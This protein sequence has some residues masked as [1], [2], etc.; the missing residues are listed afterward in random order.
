MAEKEITR[1]DGNSVEWTSV[2]DTLHVSI[3]SPEQ[4]LFEG[5]VESVSVPGEKGRFEVLKNHAPIIS[6]L[7]RGTVSCSGAT[8]CEIDIK[9]GFIEVAHNRVSLCVEE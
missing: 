8:P 6:S 9:G 5:E 1:R 7:V 4:I 2:S 3:V